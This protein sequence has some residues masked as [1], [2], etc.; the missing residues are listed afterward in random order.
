MASNSANI[1][2]NRKLYLK[3]W[4]ERK[5]YCNEFDYKIACINHEDRLIEKLQREEEMQ[6]KFENMG[7]EDLDKLDNLYRKEYTLKLSNLPVKTKWEDIKK[8]T[9][10]LNVKS[11]HIPKSKT[12]RLSLRFAFVNFWNEEDKNFAKHI[13]LVLKENKL[14]WLSGDRKTCHKCGS[15]D[16]L[17]KECSKRKITENKN[18]NKEE[19]IIKI[20]KET[21]DKIEANK[22]Q[23]EVE[24]KELTDLTDLLRAY[25]DNYEELQQKNKMLENKLEKMSKQLED[26]ERKENKNLLGEEQLEAIAEKIFQKFV[27]KLNE[28]LSYLSTLAEDNRLNDDTQE[29]SCKNNEKR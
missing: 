14:L 19:K 28:N 11:F 17:V 29:R 16:H 8:T 5:N 10:N 22:E 3:G 25:K 6:L 24:R 27:P 20:L 15:K 18:I 26:I 7:Q 2:T 21:R 1:R 13:D 12:K 23:R 4:P 9:N